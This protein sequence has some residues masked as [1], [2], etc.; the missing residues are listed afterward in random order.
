M[1]VIQK[2]R[3]KYARWAVVAIA[4]SLMGFI[5][6]DAFA[7]RTRLFGGN[8]TTIGRI[9]N[10]KLDYIDFEKKVKA[11]EEQAQQQNYQLGETG[12][13]Q[14]IETVWNQEVSSTLLEDEFQTLGLHVGKKEWS[15]ILYGANPP[16]DLKQ[17]FSDPNTGEYNAVAAQQFIT[18]IQKR[19]KPEDKA[20]LQ[21]YLS[22]LEFTRMTE[23]YATLLSGTIYF[24]KWFIEKQNIDNSLLGKASYV[25]VLY[26]TIPDNTIKVT[27]Q[28]I[29]DYI[30]QHKKEFEQKEE[31][32]GIS[33]VTFSAAPT[34][35][36]SAVI[37]T[38]L[39]RLKPQFESTTDV[40][41]FISQQGSNIPYF[42]A[43]VA[44]SKIQVPAKDSIFKQAPGQVYGPYLDA[45]S[46][47]L[48]K[49]IGTKVLPDSVK[50]RHILLGTIDPQT[51]QPTMPDTLAKRKADSVAA[52]I[53][54]GANFDSLEARYSTDQAAHKDKGVMTFSS[55]DIQGPNFAKEFG[56]FI[57]FDGK[58]G[59]KK[60]VKTNF[61]WHYIEILEH[62]NPEPHYKVAYMAKPIVASDET[63]SNASNQANLFAGDSRDLK[64]FNA[65]WEKNLKRKGINKLAATDIGPND[66]AIPGLGA[67]RTLVKAIFN[68][69]KGDVLEPERVG[70]N[71]VVAVVTEV[72]EAGIQNV[73]KAR[74]VVEPI[75]RNKKKAQQIRQ[76]IGRI[77]TLDAVAAAVNQ[78]IKTADTVRFNGNNPVFGYETKVIGAVFNPAN[79]GKIIP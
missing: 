48:A 65:N 53:K 33:Y 23:K 73:A 69:D 22:N 32:R 28:E 21:E 4:V 13:Q 11:Q 57:L 43:Y 30:N 58:P 6:M 62:K 63:E 66:Y 12:R 8:S 59:D 56:Q 3:D 76:K 70:D 16:Q 52:A 72:N 54:A 74:T 37:R 10:K 31:T 47:V 29:K 68:A 14:I 25:S 5:L 34:A 9:N 18:S 79:K 64:S 7:G 38:Q 1:S 15:D 42:D 41:I 40:T 60:V 36:D 50:C 19:G 77:T 39:E 46:Y 2:I 78:P 49:M 26:T 44:K 51:N 24:P 45:G 27:D 55:T 17:R 67:S 35:A 71:Y 61:G 75:L 20:Q